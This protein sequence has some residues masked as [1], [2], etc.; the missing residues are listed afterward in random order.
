MRWRG[1]VVVRGGERVR[2]RR[3]ERD[4]EKGLG[5]VVVVVLEETGVF[6]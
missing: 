2:A 6:F 5:E 1:R 3:A 4:L